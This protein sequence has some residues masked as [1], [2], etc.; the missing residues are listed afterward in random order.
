MIYIYI[1]EGQTQLVNDGKSKDISHNISLQKYHNNL[2]S[3]LK[4]GTND[5]TLNF[6][7]HALN[8]NLTIHDV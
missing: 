3:K 5:I 1:Y 2:Y 8:N 4:D 7:Y 6:H